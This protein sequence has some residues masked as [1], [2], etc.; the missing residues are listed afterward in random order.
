MGAQD[1]IIRQR[2]MSADEAYTLAVE[3]AIT[4][5]GN[6]QYNGTISTTSSF[7]DLTSEFRR[8]KKDGRKFV[9]EILQSAG[10]RYCF[11]IEEEPPIKNNNKI[12]SFVEHNVVKGTSKWEL[13]YNVYTGWEDRQLRSFKTKAEAVK[14][15]RAHTEK[16][17]NTT[18]VRMEKFLIN[19]DP[20]VACI[21]YK[22]SSQEKD[23]VYI[24]FGVAA[25]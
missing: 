16:T 5:N 20:N 18:F 12:K 19:Q 15:A 9:D 23:G 4:E 22:Q 13:R 3:T 8:S 2:A 24:L 11:A 17:K 25:C 7:Q 1:F 10:K 14:Y 6:D 21:K